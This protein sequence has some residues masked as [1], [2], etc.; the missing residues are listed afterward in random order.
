MS[1]TTATIIGAIIA[2]TFGITGVLA[3]IFAERFLRSRGEVSCTS[4]PLTWTFHYDS[5]PGPERRPRTMVGL[6]SIGRGDVAQASYVEFTFHASFYNGRD[7]PAGL[8]AF[9]ILFHRPDDV[10]MSYR[11]LGDRR[12]W[13]TKS[14]AARMD[15]LRVLNLPPNQIVALEITGAAPDPARLEGCNKVELRAAFPD[16]SPFSHELA[17]LDRGVVLAG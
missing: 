15:T 10:P 16:G 8:L 14:G 1:V 13:R 6:G 7:L 4:D 2:G 9:E 12:T 11:A 3:G 5:G 17:R